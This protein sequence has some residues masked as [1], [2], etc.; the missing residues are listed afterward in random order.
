MTMKISKL[1]RSWIRQTRKDFKE[2]LEET[3]FPDPKRT[4]ERGPEFRYPEWLI[5]FIAVLAVKCKLKAYK[6]IHRMSTEYW[7][8]ITQGLKLKP[9]SERQLRDRLKKICH[10][11]GKPATFIFQ[12]FPELDE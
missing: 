3:E 9:I 2:F 1:S 11:P 5:M 8:T 10:F 12:I 7:D 4:G 6:A